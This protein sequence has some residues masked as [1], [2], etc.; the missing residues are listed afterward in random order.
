MKTKTFTISI[1]LLLSIVNTFA[2]KGNIVIN[3]S[4]KDA[5]SNAT[6]PLG[7]VYVE[8][9]S[10]NCDTTVYGDNPYLY[11]EWVSGIDDNFVSK[12]SPFELEPN[13]PNPFSSTTKFNIYIKNQESLKIILCNAYGAV[14]SE[15]KKELN[16]GLHTFEIG[17]AKDNLY[18]LTVSNGK[19]SKSIKL[20]SFRHGINK[21][22]GIKYL[23]MGNNNGYKSSNEISSFVF[24]PGDQLLMRTNPP[25]YYENTMYDNP[26]ENKNY[27]FEL[28][29]ESTITL[30]TVNT[31]QIT[32]I[33]QT[34]ATSGG[35]VSN[36][37]G[38]TVTTRGV[39]WDIT[40]NPTIS[41]N[42][43]TDGGGTGSY[44][45][46]LSGLTQNTTY[47]VRAYATNSAGTNYGN[48]IN[49][50]TIAGN[51]CPPSIN[52]IDG[53]TYNT[54][55]IGTQCWMAENLK[56]TTY[57]NGAPIPNVTDDNSWA[58]LTTGAYVWYSNAIVF[59]NMYGALYNWYAVSDPNGLCPTGWHV[60]THNEWT[61]LTNSIG[62]SGSPYGSELKSCR[63]V[64]SPQPWPCNTSD[65]PRWNEYDV[66]H[67]TDDHGFSGLPGGA[68]HN[69][70]PFPPVGEGAFWW[71]S[72]QQ[73]T[74]YAWGRNL[75][76][77]QGDMSVT[78]FK[79]QFGE[80]V[81]CLKD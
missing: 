77:S 57:Q 74:G 28:Q 23:G 65:H 25:G 42:F 47:Y 20:I 24:Q 68:R 39:C 41:D 61:D 44:T 1:V 73:S 69:E 78:Y 2:Q 34:S 76:Y 35:N 21:N 67:G 17:A 22:Q 56:T 55:Q 59:K 29:P 46:S 4:G 71:S 16:H 33:T 75:F 50:E 52:D 48:Q 80:S 62:G 11:L 3:F 5:V 9:L 40:P 63:Q 19:I 18:F 6:V 51:N 45:S 14:V 26:S 12:S 15:L 49:F 72:T 38:A 81:R 70:G 8:N 13:Y 37:G 53:N 10:A 27:I 32:N 66:N 54:V 64:N 43:T 30:P 7:N 36:D 58:N 79:Y 60:P 31:S